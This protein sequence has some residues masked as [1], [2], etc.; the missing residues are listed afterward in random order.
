MRWRVLNQLEREVVVSVLRRIEDELLRCYWNKNQKEMDSPFQNTGNQY[1]CGVFAV[2]AYDWVED[3]GK[4]FVYL[5]NNFP[6]ASLRAEWYKYLGRGDY[7]E[8]NE[9]WKME[10]LAD[11]LKRCKD[12]IREDFGEDQ[13]GLDTV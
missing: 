7:V 13:N 12:A 11:M 9:N 6:Q 10:Y 3:N 5:D 8:V 2:R 1:D 4:N